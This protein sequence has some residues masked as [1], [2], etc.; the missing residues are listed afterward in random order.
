MRLPSFR[1]RPL[2][3]DVGIAALLVWGAMMG[4]RSD[5]SRSRARMYGGPDPPAPG[6]EFT[7]PENQ[8]DPK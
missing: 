6:A 2:M 7:S 5:G 3:V 1:V 4:S 8:D